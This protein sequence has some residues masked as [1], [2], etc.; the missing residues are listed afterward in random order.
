MLWRLTLNVVLHFPR[1]FVTLVTPPGQ[2]KEGEGGGGESKDSLRIH[3]HGK[4]RL[5]NDILQDP[6]PGPGDKSHRARAIKGLRIRVPHSH[7]SLTSYSH[8]TPGMDMDMDMGIYIYT[9]IARAELSSQHNREQRTA[10]SEQ[11]TALNSSLCSASRGREVPA[12][13][14]RV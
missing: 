6:D 10:N 13:R 11:R 4:R 7:L 3:T 1:K 9:L 2:D 14:L 8:S 12:K 5:A